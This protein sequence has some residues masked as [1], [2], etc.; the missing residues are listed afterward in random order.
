MTKHVG[1]PYLS[2][3]VRSLRFVLAYVGMC[4]AYK[5]Y[6]MSGGH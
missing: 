6:L 5:Y 1:G 3:D 4:L 2:G